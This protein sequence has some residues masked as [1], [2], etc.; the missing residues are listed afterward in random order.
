MGGKVRRLKTN[1]DC[2]TGLSIK[3]TSLKAYQTLK[4]STEVYKTMRQDSGLESYHRSNPSPLTLKQK[5]LQHP[6]CVIAAVSLKW[7]R[8]CMFFTQVNVRTP[9]LYLFPTT[10]PRLR[11]GCINTPTTASCLG[12]LLLKSSV[13]TESSWMHGWIF[14]IRLQRRKV[15]KMIL[16]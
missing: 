10:H 8:D 7:R 6:E 5:S 16:F 12:F 4:H 15:T 9:P 2:Q 3:S 11:L 1:Q 13:V 14:P